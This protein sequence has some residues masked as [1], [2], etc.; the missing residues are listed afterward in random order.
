VAFVIN[1][2]RAPVGAPKSTSRGGASRR[3]SERAGAGRNRAS[4]TDDE[5]DDDDDD[6][7]EELVRVSRM[8]DSEGVF[9]GEPLPPPF[10]RGSSRD[11]AEDFVGDLALGELGAPEEFLAPCF[12]GDDTG[13]VLEATTAAALAAGASL[14]RTWLFFDLRGCAGGRL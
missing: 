3:E 9:L 13:G 1:G 10:G 4:Q 14:R 5:D 2:R 12:T 11:L 6:D 8:G 7:D